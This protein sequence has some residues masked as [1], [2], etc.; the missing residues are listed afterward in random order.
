MPEHVEG[1]ERPQVEPITPDVV[2]KMEKPM[3]EKTE[4]TD[5]K[6]KS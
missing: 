3:I 6:A 4:S 1:A 2:S 5:S